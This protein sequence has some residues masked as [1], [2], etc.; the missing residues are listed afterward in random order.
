[1]HRFLSLLFLSRTWKRLVQR[2]FSISYTIVFFSLLLAFA[3]ASSGRPDTSHLSNVPSSRPLVSKPLIPERAMELRVRQDT[4][5]RSICGYVD[6]NP[7]RARV[8][9]VGWACRVDAQNALWG[10]CLATTGP[11]SDCGLRGACVD[12]HS[13]SNGCGI[14]GNTDIK[15]AT[16]YGTHYSFLFPRNNH[17]LS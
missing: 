11:V 2:F 12:A 8:A 1:M 4:Q 5:T 3:G 9:D 16:W 7:D 6:G 14:L 10:F 15:T 17:K 13:C